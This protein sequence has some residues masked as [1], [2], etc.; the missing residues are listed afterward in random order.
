MTL[1]VPIREVVLRESIRQGCWRSG[2]SP[3]FTL[4]MRLKFFH[5]LS[6]GSGG[7]VYVNV[8]VAI[9]GDNLKP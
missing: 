3:T 8:H 4:L 1:G 7:E 9:L 2:E 6:H 5:N